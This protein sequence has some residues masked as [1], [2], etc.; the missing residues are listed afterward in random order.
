MEIGDI[1]SILREKFNAILANYDFLEE[2]VSIQISA[3]SAEESIGSPK[4]RDFPLIVGKEAMIEA[5][6]RG[7]KGQA[8]TL[9][10]ATL[11]APLKDILTLDLKNDY[12]KAIYIATM[13]AVMRYLGLCDRTVHCKDEEPEECAYELSQEVENLA[14]GKN[15][16]LIGYQ[17]AIFEALTKRNVNLRVLDLNPNM[18]GQRKWGNVLVE[19]GITAYNSA[20]EW[21]EFFLVTG[22]TLANGSITNFLGLEKP[23]YFYGN[24]IAGAAK[25][26]GL[27]RLCMK[28]K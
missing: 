13:N 15:V 10:R 26:L 27:N 9:A 22:S 18:I 14:I 16:V 24:T 19:D 2:Q 28:A 21:G 17:P 12:N 5:D 6:F 20:V 7:A 23:V 11:K 3:L 25:L 8:F 1:Y 4:R